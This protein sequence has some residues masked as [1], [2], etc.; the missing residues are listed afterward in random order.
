MTEGT[1]LRR[2]TDDGFRNRGPT[3]S[4][5]GRK[6]LFYSDRAGGYDAWTVDVDGIGLTPVTRSRLGNTLV[7]PV[8]SPDGRT[9]AAGSVDDGQRLLLLPY[10]RSPEDPLPEPAPPPGEGLGCY[11]R[12]W[13]PNSRKVAA[14]ALRANGSFAGIL[15]Y[16]VGR[17]TYSRVTET[18][19]EP[20]FLR[21]GRRIAFQDGN[22]LKIVDTGSG[23]TRE[24][25][26]GDERRVLASFALSPDDKDLFVIWSVTQADLWLMDLRPKK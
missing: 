5:D 20:V 14:T 26:R 10:P 4:P 23:R 11:P 2:L 8:W 21:D 1:G 17:R 6:V 22:A 18:G 12:S 24:I 16:D 3:F 15:V 9:I 13:S 19:S 25:L 7:N